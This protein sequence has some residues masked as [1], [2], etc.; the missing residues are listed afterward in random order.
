MV[1]LL[2]KEQTDDDHKK[3]YC[4]A[5]LD[6]AEDKAKEL[7]HAIDDLDKTILDSEE[8]IKQLTEDLELL[9][10]GIK[11]LDKSVLEATEQRRKENDEYKELMAGNTAAKE[12]IEFAKNRLQKFYNPKLYKPPPKRELSEEERITLNMGGTLAPTNP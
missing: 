5:Q 2:A 8:T 4:E 6:I 12:L 9:E 11:A 10:D 3:E 7:Q 1:A